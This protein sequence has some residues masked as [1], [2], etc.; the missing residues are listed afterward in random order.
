VGHDRAD[1]GVLQLRLVKVDYNV[2][3]LASAL[4]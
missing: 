1:D 2:N 4:K 3:A